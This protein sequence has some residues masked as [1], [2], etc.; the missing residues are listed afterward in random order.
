M[1]SREGRVVREEE[2]AQGLVGLKNEV[3][4]FSRNENMGARGSGSL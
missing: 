4:K 3:V 1:K 2:E